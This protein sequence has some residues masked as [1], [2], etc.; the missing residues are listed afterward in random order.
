MIVVD[1]V[2]RISKSA[3]PGVIT[4]VA[5]DDPSGITTYAQTGALFGYSQLW[6]ALFSLPFMIAIQEMCGRIGLVTG[7]GLAQILKRHYSKK[8]LFGAITILAITNIINIGADLGAMSSAV[9]L[10][11]P[12]SFNYILIFLTLFTILTQVFF[13]YKTY[14]IFLKYFALTIL[15]YVVA[16]FFI[17]QNWHTVFLSTIIPHIEWNRA[18]LLNITAMLG[19][20]I[21][22]YLFFW[23]ASEEVEEQLLN[24]KLAVMGEGV[25]NITQNDVSQMRS[26]TAFGML[27]SNII[28]FFIIITAAGTLGKEGLTSVTSAAQVAASLE[29]LA[30]KSASLLFT[31][32]IVGTG[33]LAIPVLAGSAGYAIAEAFGWQEGLGKTFNEAKGFYLIIILS[34]LV[35]VFVN[36]S[37]ISPITMLYYAAILN[38]LLAPILMVLILLIANNKNILGERTNGLLGNIL[39]VTITLVMSFLTL[40]FLYNLF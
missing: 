19:T 1:V 31:L 30:G 10:I 29:P 33:L 32:G 37:S 39:G 15:A 12:F 18:Y 2:K 20:T 6:L 9:Q 3:G 5:D 35:G 25:P 23:Q 36:L 8:I 38:G 11:L 7:S 21:S 27:I 24:G 28:T 26:N 17:N 4:G 34:I 16:A 14:V 40:Y 13:P 22:P